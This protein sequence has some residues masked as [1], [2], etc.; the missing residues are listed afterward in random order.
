MTYC[1]YCH[2]SKYYHEIAEEGEGSDH[3][4]FGNCDCWMFSDGDNWKPEDE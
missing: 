4:H 3:C 1:D 2:H